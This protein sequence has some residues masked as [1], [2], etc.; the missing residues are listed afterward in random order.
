M[1]IFFSRFEKF[2]SL[3]LLI[4]YL[5]FISLLLGIP[6]WIYNWSMWWY[7]LSLLNFHYSFFFLLFWL[8]NFWS[9]VFISL[10]STW[11]SLLWNSSSRFFSSVVVFFSFKISVLYFLLV[12]IL[13]LSIFLLTSLCIFLMLILNS[14][15]C[16]SNIYILLWS[17]SGDS[18]PS[19]CLGHFSL[20]SIFFG[21]LY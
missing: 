21:S 5:P 10:F 18:F 20:S 11:S 15:S 4:K 1:L 14:L 2:W 12:E 17:A 3:F 6:F 13:T 7:L 9:P 19:L 8:D 16:K